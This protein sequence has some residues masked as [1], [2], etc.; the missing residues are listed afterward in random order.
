MLCSCRS[1]SFTGRKYRPGLFVSHKHHVSKPE[2][3]GQT[4]TR[5][6][7]KEKESCA[8]SSCET[9]K[10]QKYKASENRPSNDRDNLQAIHIGTIKQDCTLV[11]KSSFT[12]SRGQAIS[13]S[14]SKVKKDISDVI[15][16]LLW[17]MAG[18]VVFGVV[19][20]IIAICAILF[21][22]ANSAFFSIFAFSLIFSILACL[23]ALLVLHI[24]REVCML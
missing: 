15:K 5:S 18:L 14:H 13:A 9:L 12:S 23:L 16:I 2:I 4:I 21:L 17:V 1:G 11:Q 3:H 7:Q 22:G 8:V 10:I 6:P 20:G 24:V 19:F